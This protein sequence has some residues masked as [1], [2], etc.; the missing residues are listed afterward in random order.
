MKKKLTQLTAFLLI[1][2]SF[3]NCGLFGIGEDK[4]NNQ[5]LLLGLALLNSRSGGGGNNNAMFVAFPEVP[6]S[7]TATSAARASI[8]ENTKE[9]ATN[10]YK[11]R[12][13]TNTASVASVYDLVR[14]T[15][16][17]TRDISKSIGDL[18]A[19]LEKL[20]T[21]NVQATSTGAA[22]GWA[23]QPA[24]FRYATSTTIISGRKLEVWWN[25]APAPYSNNKAIEMNFT[26]SS[27][28][29]DMSG[30]IFCRF[31]AK[32]G[33]ATL[34]KAY[35]KF[36][37]KASSKLKRMAVIMQ[38]IGP[39]FTDT[40]H[41]YVQE[42]NGITTM[43]G[44]YSV[45]NYSPN[46]TG[47]VAANR[48]YIFNAAGDSS[49]AVMN[50]MLPLQTD[51]TA[52]NYLN[53]TNGNIGQVWTNFILASTNLTV[54]NTIPGCTT[55]SATGLT[56]GNPTVSAPLANYSITTLKACMDAN[57]P[58]TNFK[59]L[60]FL[61]NIKNPAY[62]NAS[63]SNATLYGVESLD[64]ADS[65]RAAF[66]NLQVLL[67]TTTRSSTSREYQADFSPTAISNLNLFTGV[68]VP[69]GTTPNT[70]PSINAMWGGNTAGT[71]ISTA[72]ATANT[73]NG[74][75]DNTAPF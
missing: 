47:V 16:K 28:S 29:G 2:G 31:L 65:N 27:A 70:F 35:I 41:F 69:Q 3:I 56:S 48:I 1:L 51:T 55:I 32:T 21:T 15:A 10:D 19:S 54:L 33:D 40:A 5:N 66:T 9:L 42:E 63:G 4:D 61:T 52:V 14:I 50:A 34:G 30:Y 38:D 72:N 74:S 60:Y 62:F 39:T 25:A 75:A 71:G 8:Q 45:D 67:L 22:D 49:K 57:N 37:Y 46:L 12:N 23:N 53:L 68:N 24:K 36:D 73:V 13:S 11:F 44:G 26:G 6:A 17:S 7:I 58:A 59:D 64:L 18:V 20:G 43:D